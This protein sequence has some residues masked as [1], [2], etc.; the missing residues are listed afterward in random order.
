MYMAGLGSVRLSTLAYFLRVLPYGRKER[1]AVLVICVLVTVTVIVGEIT[2]F[3]RCTPAVSDT[4]PM[5]ARCYSLSKHDV[6]MTAVNTGTA[7]LIGFATL[8]IL[9]NHELAKPEYA[10]VFF[11]N[12]GTVM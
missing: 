9:A 6:V 2:Y 12:G 1:L 3:L 8:S 5:I 7:V 11:V 4:P 10:G